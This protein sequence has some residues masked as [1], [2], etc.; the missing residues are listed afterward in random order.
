MAS[1][2]IDFATLSEL[3][4][5]RAEQEAEYG[6][7]IDAKEAAP[8]PDLVKAWERWEVALRAAL[9]EWVYPRLSDL[10]QGEAYDDADELVD[11]LLDSDKGNAS[12]NVLMTLNGEGVGIWDGRWDGWL[13][14]SEIESL[15]V[16]LDERLGA[17]ADETGGGT[18][19]ADI[20]TSAYATGGGDE[21]DEDDEDDEG[22]ATFDPED[23]FSFESIE[24]YQAAA[25]P[26]DFISALEEAG[27]DPDDWGWAEEPTYVGDA[28][29]VSAYRK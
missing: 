2:W 9:K 11:E 26:D 24:D 12:Y 3:V 22:A 7:A 1:L 21:D 10:E 14:E 6:H 13:S 4:T 25:D 16:L 17:F 15:S 23:G 29:I 5:A 18:L 8:T 20:E 19:N 27:E 28:V